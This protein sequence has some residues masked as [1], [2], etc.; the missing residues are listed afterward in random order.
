M[1]GTLIPVPEA[2]GVALHYASPTPFPFQ[3]SGAQALEEIE[4]GRALLYVEDSPGLNNL[5][6]SPAA[7]KR[8]LH[9]VV[10]GRR[11]TLHAL[12]Q[13]ELGHF[14]PSQIYAAEK[15][16]TRYLLRGD[17][18]AASRSPIVVRPWIRPSECDEEED[19]HDRDCPRVYVVTAGW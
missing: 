14:R 1:H 12:P 18:P 15:P 7:L 9:E 19:E 6:F 11:G 17:A 16:Q 4:E 3:S 13:G 10:S 8:T 5:D 2:E